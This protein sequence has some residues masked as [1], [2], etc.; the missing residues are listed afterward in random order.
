M[1]QRRD[2]YLHLITFLDLTTYFPFGAISELPNNNKLWL[3]MTV[4][5]RISFKRFTGSNTGLDQKKNFPEMSSVF[6]AAFL[7]SALWYFAKFALEMCNKNPNE[8]R[9]N[10]FYSSKLARY[11]ITFL[12]SLFVW[13]IHGSVLAP[14]GPNIGASCTVQLL[15]LLGFLHDGSQ[16]SVVS[17]GGRK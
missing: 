12:V 16:W 1:P 11:T 4:R 10:R 15:S 5:I 8:P 6:K 14:S 17:A 7:K 9:L 3:Y 13:F 2:S